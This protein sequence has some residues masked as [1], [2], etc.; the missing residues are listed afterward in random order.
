MKS[1]GLKELAPLLSRKDCRFVSLQYGDDG[2]HLERFQ[3]SC[4]ID[5]LHDDSIDA[6]KDMD[7]WLSQVAAMDAVLSIANTT[8]HG[9]GGLGI[10]SMCLVSRQS[11]EMDRTVSL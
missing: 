7:G 4:G 5:V 3:K 6:L 10:P 2:P 9:A 8:I 1:I 11:D